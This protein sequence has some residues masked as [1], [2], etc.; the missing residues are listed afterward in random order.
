MI[1]LVRCTLAAVLLSI[2]AGR[3]AISAASAQSL[4]VP[5]RGFINSQPGESC[6]DKGGA[7]EPWWNEEAT[8][9]SALVL[10]KNNPGPGL[11]EKCRG[12][13]AK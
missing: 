2:A 1:P 7:L 4:P 12:R 6:W 5:E 8:T 11:K 3:L 10:E 9:T 13:S